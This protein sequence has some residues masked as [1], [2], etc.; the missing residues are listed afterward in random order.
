MLLRVVAPIVFGFAGV[1]VIPLFGAYIADTRLGRYKTICWAVGIALFGHILLIISAVPTVIEK[2]HASVAVFSLALII[3]GLGSKS[4]SI[5][6][7]FT[8]C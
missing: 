5:I 2:P 6:F 4:L 1:Y 8:E 3:M 7:L